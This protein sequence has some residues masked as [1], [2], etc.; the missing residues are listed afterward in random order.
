MAKWAGRLKHGTAQPV[1]SVSSARHCLILFTSW[2]EK[3]NLWAMLDHA[4]N[5]IGAVMG[6]KNTLVTI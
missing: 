4:M 6:K 5:S 1:N 3:K 2:V